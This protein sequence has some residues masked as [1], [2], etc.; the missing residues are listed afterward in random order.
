M[1]ELNQSKLGH[2][3]KKHKVRAEKFENETCSIKRREKGIRDFTAAPFFTVVYCVPVMTMLQLNVESAPAPA[4]A[5]RVNVAK[6]DVPA[7]KVDNV[8]DQVTVRYVVASGLQVL[9]AMVRFSA[10]FPVFLM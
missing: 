3:P 2:C 10:M 4:D 6:V 7:A 5:V 9:V 1:Q 8:G